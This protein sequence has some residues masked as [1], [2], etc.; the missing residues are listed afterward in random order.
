VSELADKFGI[1]DILMNVYEPHHD[2]QRTQGE[3][4][5]SAVA[6]QVLDQADP[7]L[8]NLSLKF[9]QIGVLQRG[10]QD[11][12]VVLNSQLQL[13]ESQRLQVYSLVQ[14]YG[15]QLEQSEHELQQQYQD[16]ISLKANLESYSSMAMGDVNSLRLL[17]THLTQEQSDLS[18][19]A[20]A[21]REEK[22]R[23]LAEL[24]ITRKDLERLTAETA[25]FDVNS[26]NR[27]MAAI[28]FVGQPDSLMGMN[29][30]GMP[31]NGGLPGY[32]NAP[33]AGHPNPGH[34]N[35]GHPGHPN[36]TFGGIPPGANIQY[37]GVEA[38]HSADPSK[39]ER[40]K[41]KNIDMTKVEKRTEKNPGPSDKSKKDKDKKGKKK[42]SNAL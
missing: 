40:R 9:E 32:S 28:S 30:G 24:D 13:A 25:D 14:D 36:P 23:T 29:V 20:D 26:I 15:T 8:K 42:K 38:E 6:Q 19:Q 22:S 21:L 39:R 33:Y 31:Y 18:A 2:I 35:P 12:S 17:R 3:V 16:L 10:L 41:S 37:T 7:E 1:S 34:P 5:T 27:S 4:Q 11:K